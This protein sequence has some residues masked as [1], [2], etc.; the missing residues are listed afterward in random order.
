MLWVC[1][2]F[3]WPQAGQIPRYP[4]EV[5]QVGFSRNQTT[6]NADDIGRYRR[7]RTQ[8]IL[9]TYS[10]LVD[11]IAYCFGQVQI[12]A[13]PYGKD[14]VALA[15][16]DTGV[17]MTEEDLERAL[18]PYQQAETN[19]RVDAEGKP[20]GTGLGLPISKAL[21][22]ANRA[23][24]RIESAKDAGTRVEILFNRARVAAE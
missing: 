4:I 22:E 20:V 23:Q 7:G 24:F 9:D 8:R 10:N 13:K 21:A 5:G 6:R 16:S 2:G 12:S 11:N 1:S 17:G 15:V 19:E 14:Q 18:S 3:K